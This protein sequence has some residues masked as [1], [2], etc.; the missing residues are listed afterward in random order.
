MVVKSRN[1]ITVLPADGTRSPVSRPSSP[2]PSTRSRCRSPPPPTSRSR[3]YRILKQLLIWLRLIKRILY[4]QIYQ[5]ASSDALNRNAWV[6]VPLT[7]V[8]FWQPVMRRSIAIQN[9]KTTTCVKMNLKIRYDM[10]QFILSSVYWNVF[11]VRPRE[12][13]AGQIS[14]P[15]LLN[16]D[17]IEQT[18]Y[19]GRGIK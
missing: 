12:Q 9:T 4:T 18:G 7:N 5:L 6:N 14:T 3:L 17:Y 2:F 11:L 19:P 8:E 13:G 15:L 10:G 16:T 1:G